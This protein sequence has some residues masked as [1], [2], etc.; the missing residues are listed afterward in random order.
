MSAGT[1]D[2]TVSALRPGRPVRDRSTWITYIQLSCFAWFMYGFGATQA[3]LRD[4]QGTTRTISSLHST[5]LATA[6]IIA[7]LLTSRVI[8]RFGRGVVLRLGSIGVIVGVVVYTMPSGAYPVTMLGAFITS[9]F[10]T[11]MLITIN[12]YLIDHQGPAGSAAITEGNGIASIAGLLAPLAIG[13]GAATILGWR[14]GLL[15]VAVGLVIVEVWRG[16]SVSTYDDAHHA[17]AVV[18]KGRMPKGFAWTMVVVMCF[19]G[20]EFSLV[21]WGA[22]L[23]RER[24]LFGP[25]A[26]AASVAAVTGGMAVG[27]FAGARAAQTIANDRILKWSILIAVIG[28][29][30]AWATQSAITILI[31][32]LITGIGIGVHWPLGVAR[33]VAASGGR[34]DRASA[35]ASVFGSVAIAS[36]PF[37]LGALADAT[38]FHIA[39]LMVPTMLLVALVVMI[40]KPVASPVTSQPAP[41]H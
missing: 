31:G 19:L 36:A 14:W 39:L 24:A 25:A 16:R 15:M 7:G 20:A 40:A 10:G 9:F 23:L 33:A 22:D 3:L 12:A 5:S 41:A 26:A 13:I 17:P 11:L 4:E 27:R 8:D 37:A 30:M 28:F 2:S 1:S 32:M 34:T 35:L 21:Y 29:A 18:E 6:G 38:S